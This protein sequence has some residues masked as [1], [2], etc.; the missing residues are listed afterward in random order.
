ML[1]R[2]RLTPWST[3]KWQLPSLTS[4]ITR[5]WNTNAERF[6]RLHKYGPSTVPLVEFVSVLSIL[7]NNQTQSALTINGGQFSF[8]TSVRV[9]LYG[10]QRS[11]YRKVTYIHWMGIQISPNQT[12]TTWSSM[13]SSA[14]PATLRNRHVYCPECAVSLAAPMCNSVPVSDCS[15]QASGTGTPSCKR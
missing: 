4:V 13:T 7:F 8:K 14:I 9:M 1:R 15:V 12:G 11:L 2:W 6:S 5:V 3:S 10:Q